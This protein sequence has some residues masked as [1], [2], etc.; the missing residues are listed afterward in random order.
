MPTELGQGGVK[1]AKG[2]KEGELKNL[3]KDR[4]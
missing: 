1:E 4:M 3:P 2:S